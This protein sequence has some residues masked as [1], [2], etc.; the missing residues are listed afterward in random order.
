VSA[1]PHRF[2]FSGPGG[3]GC[4]LV[5]G[6]IVL[7][8]SFLAVENLLREPFSLQGTASALWL[9]LV[10]L[11]LASCAQEEKGARGALK[12]LLSCFSQVHFVE[13]DESGAL[14]R[15][16][17]LWAAEVTLDSL[18]LEALASI[19]W[20]QGQASAMTGRDMDDWSVLLWF[21]FGG[22][23]RDQLWILGPQ[24]ALP[25]AE[26][27][28]ERAVAFLRGCGLGLRRESQRGYV[29]PG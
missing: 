5:V 28:G 23:A 2:L 13:L 22:L 15:G 24:Q 26:E 19:R 21:E 9:G 7:V 18:P 27:I 17:R 16:F 20:S 4:A 3:G 29:I 1:P 6:A 14:R 25:G 10:G 8:V 11:S 12:R